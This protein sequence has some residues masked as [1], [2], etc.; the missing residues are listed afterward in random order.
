MITIDQFL[1]TELRVATVTAAEMIPGSNK[2]LKLKADLG[3]GDERV[4][5]AGIAREYAPDNL[6]GRQVVVVTNLQPARLMGVESRG[7]V[8][9]A[10]GS[11]A[12]VLLRP[13]SPVPNGTRVQ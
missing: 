13:D 9:A 1:D 4:L 5:V 2:L 12:P 11:G 10:A 6:V 3:E 8:L 7:M